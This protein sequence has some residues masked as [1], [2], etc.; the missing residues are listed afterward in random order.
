MFML[1]DSGTKIL[2]CNQLKMV[3]LEGL[4]DIDIQALDG[5]ALSCVIS[6]PFG[7]PVVP[8]VYRQ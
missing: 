6:Q 8:E 7:V 4:P 3:E 2:L 5:T 1:E